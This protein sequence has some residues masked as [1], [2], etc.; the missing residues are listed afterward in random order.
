LIN[1]TLPL[2]ST[3]AVLF[4][5]DGT[6]CYSDFYLTSL[7]KARAAFCVAISHKPHLSTPLLAAY[8]LSNGTIKPEGA[9]AVASRPNNL[10]STATVLAIDGLAW[11]EAL[12]LAEAAFNQADG[13]MAERKA[14]LTKPTIGLIPML[15]RLQAKGMSM[16]ILSSDTEPSLK[17]FL[18]YH[19]L[20]H[21]FKAVH[22][23]EREPAKPAPAAVLNLCKE[24]GVTPNQ[25][26]LVGDAQA[27][28]NMAAAA[29]ISW[30]L[31]YISG[32]ELPLQLSGS[33]GYVQH[34]DQLVPL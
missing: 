5:K 30:N 24:L 29:G 10:I 3:K 18:E 28:L 22:G 8:G 32:W 33:H 12:S 20:A 7:A 11:C 6:L 15:Q 9:T 16:A 2:D 1:K 23:A 14:Q 27:D 21:F 13:A 4:D 19:Q 34:W 31:A 25:C 17:S 26:G